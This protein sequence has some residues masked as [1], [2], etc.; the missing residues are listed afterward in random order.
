MVTATPAEIVVLGRIP[1]VGLALLREVGQVWAWDRDEPIP[2]EVRD[3]RLATADGLYAGTCSP[4]KRKVPGSSG[5]DP[6]G[7]GAG[8]F[9]ANVARA[10]AYDGPSVKCRT[11]TRG[12]RCH[13]RRP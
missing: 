12:A 8:V 5:A 9:P 7:P 6:A 11:M 10:L 3:A 1:E 2:A 13:V 4:G